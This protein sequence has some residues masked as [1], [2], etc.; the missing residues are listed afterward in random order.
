MWAAGYRLGITGPTVRQVRN[1]HDFM[2]D[3]RSELPLYLQAEAMM[4]VIA[5][6]VRAGDGIADN[7]HR[8]YAQLVRQEWVGDGEMALIDA[9][10]EDL[11]RLG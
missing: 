11:A 5:D 10:L 8:V 9:W 7:L 3:F 4:A 1:D 6:A 2:D